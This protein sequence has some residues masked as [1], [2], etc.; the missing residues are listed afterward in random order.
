MSTPVY[1]YLPEQNP[2][3]Q[4]IDGVPLRDLSPDDLAALPPDRVAAV[5]SA[6]YYREVVG[7]LVDRPVVEDPTLATVPPAVVEAAEKDKATRR[8]VEVKA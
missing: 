7:V 2:D 1:M 5:K 3:R 6:P 4:Y 8:R